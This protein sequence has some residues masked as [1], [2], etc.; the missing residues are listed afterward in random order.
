[1]SYYD[2]LPISQLPLAATVQSTDYYPGV[3][4]TDLTE[5]PSGTTKKYSIN[6]LQEYL[7]NQFSG[8][9]IRTA[10]A[11]SPLN[12]DAAY[13]NGID[14]VGATLTNTGVYGPISIDNYA[15]SL[16]DRFLVPFQTDPAHNGVYEVTVVGTAGTPWVG[17]RVTD[18]DGSPQGRIEQGDFIGILFG[19]LNS[20]SFWFLT[21]P[22]VVVVGT[23]PIIFQEQDVSSFTFTD[24]LFFAT[25]GSNLNSGTNIDSPFATLA[26]AVSVAESLI[27]IS[28]RFVSIIGVGQGVE[29]GNIIVT[30]S[31]ID[32]NAPGW[33]HNPI[34]GDALT[35]N[36]TSAPTFG[37]S[38]FNAI[39]MDST[40]EPGAKCVNLIS[41]VDGLTNVTR[42]SYSGAL[43]GDVFLNKKCECYSTIITGLLTANEGGANVIVQNGVGVQTD[44]T[45]L[46]LEGMPFGAAGGAIHG[47]MNVTNI[48]RY[49]MR[50]PIF[51]T[52]DRTLLFGESGFLFINNTTNDYVIT[53]PDTTGQG[54]P[55]FL[56]CYEAT[57]LNLSTGSI[58]FV[59]GG[60]AT[61]T[62]TTVLNEVAQ[63][64]NCTLISADSWEVD[65]AAAPAFHPDSV[66]YVAKDSDPN[67]SGTNINF[68]IPSLQQAVD[69][70]DSFPFSSGLIEILDASTYQ[71]QLTISGNGFVFVNGP[72]ANVEFNDPILSAVNVL[73][74]GIDNISIFNMAGIN[75]YAGGQIFNVA[76]S[77]SNVFLYAQVCQG[78]IY[79]EGGFVAKMVALVGG[80]ID[81]PVGGQSAIDVVNTLFVTTNI[82]GILSLTSPLCSGSTF[83]I[84]P[85]GQFFV[86]VGNP[87]G[88]S[89]VST[90]FVQGTFGNTTYNDQIF[91]GSITTQNIL[92]DVTSGPPSA[93]DVMTY[94]GINTISLQPPAPSS[95]L[96]VLTTV[97]T[98]SG[99]YTPTAGMVS[100]TVEC[101]GS[102]GG[103]GGVSSAAGQSAAAGGGGG[104]A[105][106][107]ST[108][109]AVAIGVS[110]AVTVGTGGAGG[111]AGNNNGSN[112]AASSLGALVSADGGSGG[113]GS[114]PSVTTPSF[115]IYGAGGGSGVGQ[116]IKNGDSGLLGLA[117]GASETGIG[118]QGGNSFYGIGG[119]QL[120]NLPGANGFNY[121]SG[122]GGASSGN[123][124][125]AAGGNGADGVVIITEYVQV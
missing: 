5:S 88:S 119:E 8:N 121:G 10:K 60:V 118:G 87:Q 82:D 2:S 104:G 94:D 79:T 51:L 55:A 120:I 84:N 15:L 13:V 21:S 103:G 27:T 101:V 44:Q 45:R 26:H 65:L 105:Y 28:P 77:I 3:D 91:E 47:P 117:W 30:K 98:T 19:D 49:P 24:T 56:F 37:G 9:D 115:G 70:V 86:E 22:D 35:V 72:A 95:S 12:L 63:R 11:A 43:T 58:S 64:A 17:T 52:G 102:G 53:L 124:G 106:A 78:G 125:S 97:F 92:L 109:S 81:I 112:G 42:F 18:F 6:M 108:L 74:S 34:T 23:D 36:I 66:V 114:G 90:G 50:K 38:Y 31:G 96:S 48:W 25:G 73:N 111:A 113:F 67:N 32:I 61:L 59:P 68:P 1:M 85:T 107:K 76:G 89:I 62:G 54:T 99:T 20:L 41:I 33:R 75:N 69:L 14:G 80:N 57:F 40:V 7:T 4:T 29:T 100:C 83:T 71:E 110:Q 116:I 16:G 46:N 93:G 123:T 39:L 122:G